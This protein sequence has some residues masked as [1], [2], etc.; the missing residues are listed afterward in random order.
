MKRQ[1]Q[2]LAIAVIDSGVGMGPEAIERIGEP[3]FQAQDGL[4][5]NYEGTGLGLSIVKGL[6]DLHKG[7][8]HVLSTL[9][10]GTIMTVFLPINAPAIKMDEGGSVTPLHREPVQHQTATWHDQKRKAL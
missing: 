9:G 10:Q 1:G 3:F 8:L 4:T 2:N 7:S 5:R 6:V